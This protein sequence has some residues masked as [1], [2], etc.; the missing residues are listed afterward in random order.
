MQ[1]N[2]IIARNRRIPDKVAGYVF[3]VLRWPSGKFSD[4]YCLSIEPAIRLF[5]K[6]LSFVPA[7]ERELATA[8]FD[9]QARKARGGLKRV[10]LATWTRAQPLPEFFRAVR[11]A[12]KLMPKENDSQGRLIAKKRLISDAI[13][14][15]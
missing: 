7:A 3:F 8:Y 4:G 1:V 2:R 14:S 5:T 15:A 10:R 11:R 6:R 9:V 13:K 12:W